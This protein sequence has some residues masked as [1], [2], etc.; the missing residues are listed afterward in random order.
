[1]TLLADL[2]STVFERRYRRHEAGAA[3][4]GRPLTE[5][6]DALVGSAG[7]TSDRPPKAPPMAIF[8]T[9]TFWRGIP[10]RLD[11][12]LDFM[13]GP[14]LGVHISRLPA[15]SNRAAHAKG[16]PWK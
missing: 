16:S 10:R 12:G 3:L 2:L 7:E 11:R 6:A 9:L 13:C 5:L 8:L 1:M 14:P 15:S 4:D